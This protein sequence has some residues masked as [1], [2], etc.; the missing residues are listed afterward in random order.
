MANQPL[1]P[2]QQFKTH[3]GFLLSGGDFAT[4]MDFPAT[5]MGSPGGHV[6]ANFGINARRDIVGTYND[7][8]GTAHGFLLKLEDRDEDE[9]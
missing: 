9:D 7:A 3:Y 6:T 1:P 5:T 2:E 8:K 4:T